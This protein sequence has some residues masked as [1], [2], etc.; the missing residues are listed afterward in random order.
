MSTD[1]QYQSALDELH[2]HE[3]SYGHFIQLVYVGA[4]H[5]ANMLIALAIGGVEGHWAVALLIM[6]LAVGLAAISLA[7]REKAAMAFLLLF[8]VIILAFG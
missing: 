3:A 1:V 8:S 6:F 5:I 4:V 2:I 7:R